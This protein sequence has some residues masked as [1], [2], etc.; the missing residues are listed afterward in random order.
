MKNLMMFLAIPIVF[1]FSSCEKCGDNISLG[2]YTLIE[3]TK[4]DWYIYDGLDRLSF[5]NTAG[6]LIALE[7]DEF[8]DRQ[9]YTPVTK[10]CNE[11]F[12]DSAEEYYNGEWILK[13]Y[14]TV[15]NDI[16]YSIET[17][18]QVENT[19]TSELRLYDAVNFSSNV[20]N[21]NDSDIG[22]GGSV[23]L[24]ANDRGNTF[25]Q[26][27]DELPVVP[28][29]AAEI[30]INGVTYQNVYYFNRAGVPSIYVQ[31]NQG[32]IAF[33]GLDGELWIAE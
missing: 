3:T 22:V 4:Q 19:S 12:G 1:L 13:R 27:N 29:F 33:A 15:H 32:I 25:A 2:D 21:L 20:D 28:E 5:K 23:Y 10:I 26:P 16:T 8:E 11:G 18:L 9:L 17:V 14:K 30:D 24:F 6:D 7:I 31:R